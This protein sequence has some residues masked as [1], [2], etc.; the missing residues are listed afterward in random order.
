MADDAGLLTNLMSLLLPCNLTREEYFEGGRAWAIM[1][2]K[3]RYQYVEL[4]RNTES[5]QR[6]LKAKSIAA[7]V[8]QGVIP[9]ELQ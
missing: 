8:I 5:F 4:L 2:P 9:P 7:L 6:T 3:S 1:S